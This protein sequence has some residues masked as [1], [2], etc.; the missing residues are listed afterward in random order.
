MENEDATGEKMLVL[1]DSF[2]EAPLEVVV[3][4]RALTRGV[5]ILAR[6]QR[7]F[8]KRCVLLWTIWLLPSVLKDGDRATS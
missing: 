2:P 1:V 8:R 3:E 6:T 5:E 4:S 7:L